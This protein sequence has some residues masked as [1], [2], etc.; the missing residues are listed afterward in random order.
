MAEG[1]SQ[2]KRG[3]NGAAIAVSLACGVVCL[4]SVVVFV[5]CGGGGSSNSSSAAPDPTPVPLSA[6]DVQNVVNTAALSVNVPIVIAV[7][8]RLGNVLAVFDVTGAPANGTGNFSKSQNAHE[9]AV[10]LARTAAFFSNSQAP[11]SSRTVRFISG[12]HFPPG[13]D[14][15]PNAALYG[16]ENTNRG[17]QL[18]SRL[19]PGL[20][21]AKGTLIDGKTLGLGVITGKA[22]YDDD[23]PFAVNPGGVPI[24]KNNYLTGGVGVVADASKLGSGLANQVAEYAAIIGAS[25]AADGLSATQQP[26]PPPGAVVIDGVTLPFV[27]Q[28]NIP[29]GI[30]P[31]AS[32]N[33]SY[34]NDFTCP[35]GTSPSP[36]CSGAT[37]LDGPE[38]VGKFLIDAQ[39]G[40]IL[41]RDDVTML[42]NN[43][44]AT[45]AATR[46]LIR[47]PLESRT[48]MSIAVADTDGTLL[49][50]YRMKDGTVFS[51]DVAVAKAR[52]V[53]NFSSAAGAK[54]L[55]GI[56]AGTAVTNRT[57]SFGAQPLFPPGINESNPGPFYNL[58]TYDVAHPCTQGQYS[59]PIQF[60]SGIVFFPGSEPLYK[61]GVLVGG[62]GVS[63]D[64]VD[65]DDYVTD[66]GAAGFQAPNGI[67]ADQ[68]FINGVRLPYLKFPRNP[69]G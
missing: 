33:G 68:I 39:A 17:C 41:T 67:R 1:Q 43:A 61:N 14:N 36:T 10:A 8:D 66:G 63:G 46:A 5:S 56:P 4:L 9:L 42:V 2:K 29:P 25:K 20:D 21:V 7:S 57:I 6:S 26:L 58:Y 18:D 27:D 22:S 60:P 62:L 19:T 53:A 48:R 65:Q 59:P 15:A 34:L 51:I 40:S 64:G 35:N 47:L 31:A 52:N 12:I 13:V 24:F 23:A 69:R 45:A 37:P 54:D 30:S 32:V 3:R 55:P 44:I 38:K 50:L 11:L 49:A 16:I 28:T